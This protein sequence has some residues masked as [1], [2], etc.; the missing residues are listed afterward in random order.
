MGRVTQ[1][2]VTAGRGQDPVSRGPCCW[3]ACPWPTFSPV[4][5]AS[6]PELLEGPPGSPGKGSSHQLCL[7]GANPCVFSLVLLQTPGSGGGGHTSAS[8]PPLAWQA[9]S[10]ADARPPGSPRAMV[11]TLVPASPV[12]REPQSGTPCPPGL[13]PPGGSPGPSHPLLPHLLA[14]PFVVCILPQSVIST[15]FSISHYQLLKGF[16]RLSKN[17]R[18]GPGQHLLPGAA[19]GRV[20]IRLRPW[21]GLAWPHLSHLSGLRASWMIGAL[22]PGPTAYGDPSRGRGSWGRVLVK[23]CLPQKGQV[24]SHLKTPVRNRRALCL[25]VGSGTRICVFPGKGKHSELQDLRARHEN[26][27]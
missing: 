24:R 25:P 4:L 7:Q 19:A 21:G 14:R 9:K 6:C 15:G 18:L 3:A 13:G 12:W 1:R 2:A 11:W 8:S 17:R 27:S 20:C 5:S 26:V 22:S 16:F 23:T 10:T